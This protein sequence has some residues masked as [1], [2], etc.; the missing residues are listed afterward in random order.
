MVYPSFYSS[1]ANKNK[2]VSAGVLAKLEK[3]T[4]EDAV[5]QGVR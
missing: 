3:L 2:V 4:Q 5:I 1:N